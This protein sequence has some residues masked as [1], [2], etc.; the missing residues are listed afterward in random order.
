VKMT[1]GNTTLSELDITGNLH[2]A[3][4]VEENASF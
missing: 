1:K 3:G 4:T 2:I